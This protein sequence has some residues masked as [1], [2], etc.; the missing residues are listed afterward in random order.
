MAGI[1]APVLSLNLVGIVVN[2]VFV[3]SKY[4]IVRVSIAWYLFSDA[5][6]C[7]ELT[8]TSN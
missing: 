1:S 6:I 8:A 5:V 2:H 7:L 3:R 4:F